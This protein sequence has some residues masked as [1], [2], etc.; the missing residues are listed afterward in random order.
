MK[1]VDWRDVKLSPFKKNFYDPSPEVT[2]RSAADVERF[3]TSKEIT[4]IQV[5]FFRTNLFCVLWPWR[6]N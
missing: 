4:I 2:H 6:I 1:A 5:G 3:R